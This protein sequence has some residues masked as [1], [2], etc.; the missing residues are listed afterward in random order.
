MKEDKT[1]TKIEEQIKRDENNCVPG[2][3]AH[4]RKLKQEQLEYL[5]SISIDGGCVSSK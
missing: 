5:K 1:M 3:L 2:S 4:D